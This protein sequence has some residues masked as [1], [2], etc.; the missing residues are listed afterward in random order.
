MY[1]KYFVDIIYNIDNSCHFIFQILEELRINVF[2]YCLTDPTP[3]GSNVVSMLTG[4]APHAS[5]ETL[6][7]TLVSNFQPGELAAKCRPCLPPS[8]APANSEIIVYPRIGTPAAAP[9]GRRRGHMRCSSDLDNSRVVEDRWKTYERQR[10]ADRFPGN[11]D[12]VMESSNMVTSLGLET[13]PAHGLNI[14]KR[15]V[16]SI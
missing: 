4:P 9:A 10:G 11:E 16:I 6:E 2:V 8:L 5:N 14:Q 3:H 13:R 7:D 1:F 12:D 15:K